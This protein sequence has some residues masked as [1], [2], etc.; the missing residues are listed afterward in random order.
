MLLECI[1]VYF[2]GCNFKCLGTIMN[3]KDMYIHVYNRVSMNYPPVSI[4][5]EKCHSIYN[6]QGLL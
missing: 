5:I 4:C 2:S 3:L 6:M 1:V